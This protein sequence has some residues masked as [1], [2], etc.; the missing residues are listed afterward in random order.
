[1][2]NV[3]DANANTTLSTYSLT[4]THISAK[5]MPSPEPRKPLMQ[6]AEDSKRVISSPA[7]ARVLWILWYAASPNLIIVHSQDPTVI[8]S[9]ARL[10]KQNSN[11][12]TA[13][14]PHMPSP[15]PRKP[16]MQRAEDSKRVI[17]SPAEARVSW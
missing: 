13:I 12:Y 1:M 8:V 14:A 10:L 11:T 5:Q 17:S 2:R 7:E 16:L 3:L 9:A 6:R 15:E 4:E